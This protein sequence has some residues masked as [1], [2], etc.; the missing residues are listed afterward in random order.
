MP[1]AEFPAYPKLLFERDAPRGPEPVLERTDMESGP[2]KQ[3]VRASRAMTRMPVRYHLASKAD[4]LAF[5]A[6]HRDTLHQG[7]DWFTWTD[8]LTAAA[9]TVRIVG[10]K[11]EPKVQRKDHE[12][13]IV[14]FELEYWGP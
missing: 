13:W 6:W 10:G 9:R 5:L 1:L 2:P 7:A 3:I 12:R 11:I 14:G 8:P 4:Y